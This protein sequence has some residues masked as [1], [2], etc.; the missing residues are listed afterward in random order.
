MRKYMGQIMAEC[1]CEIQEDCTLAQRCM[2]EKS[3]TVK[4]NVRCMDCR[5]GGYGC[6]GLPPGYEQ[7]MMDNW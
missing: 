7:R 3:P 2:A 6:P 5:C 4:G 1:D